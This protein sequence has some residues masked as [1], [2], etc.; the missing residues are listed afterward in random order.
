MRVTL[1]SS[2]EAGERW[3]FWDLKAFVALERIPLA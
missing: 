3:L 2:F 1:A